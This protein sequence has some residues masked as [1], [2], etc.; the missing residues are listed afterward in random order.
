MLYC[1]TRYGSQ[2]FQRSG[3][4]GSDGD[5]PHIGTRSLPNSNSGRSNV[6]ISGSSSSGGG[7]N[8]RERTSCT[9]TSTPSVKCVGVV[10]RGYNTGID[11]KAMKIVVR[12][13]FCR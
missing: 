6:I 7:G 13:S 3:R 8:E 12:A 1:V 2:R 4:I 9:T 5:V 11:D 10:Y